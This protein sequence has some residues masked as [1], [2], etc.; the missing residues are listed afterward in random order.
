MIEEPYK[1]KAGAILVNPWAA[2]GIALSAGI[3]YLL[4]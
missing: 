2:A 1:I 3:D 4:T